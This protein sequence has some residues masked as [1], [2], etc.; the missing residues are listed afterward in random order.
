LFSW[1]GVFLLLSSCF[2]LLKWSVTYG[3]SDISG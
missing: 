3:V 2:C 1:G